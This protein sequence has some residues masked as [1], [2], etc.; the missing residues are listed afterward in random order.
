MARNSTLLKAFVALATLFVAAPWAADISEIAEGES[1]SAYC[2]KQVGDEDGSYIELSQKSSNASGQGEQCYEWWYRQNDTSTVYSAL[3]RMFRAEYPPTVVV[4]T[5]DLYFGGYDG[6]RCVSGANAYHPFDFGAEEGV[7]LSSI[8]SSPY[9]IKDLCYQGG[10]SEASF[11]GNLFTSIVNVNFDNL[12]LESQTSAGLFS[13]NVETANVINVHVSHSVVMAPVAGTLAGGIGSI[14]V[15]GFSG[16][17][18]TVNA[19]PEYDDGQSFSANE[20]SIGSLVGYCSELTVSSARIDSV[21]VLYQPVSGRSYLDAALPDG[22]AYVGGLVGSVANIDGVDLDE[23]ATLFQVGLENMEVVN[24]AEGD[25]V[26]HVGGLFGRMEGSYLSVMRTYTVGD[27]LCTSES[28]VQGYG[29]GIITLTD[30]PYVTIRANYHYSENEQERAQAFAGKVVGRYISDYADAAATGAPDTVITDE[31]NKAGYIPSYTEEY[32]DEEMVFVKDDVTVATGNYRNAIGD[33]AATDNFNSE[34]YTFEDLAAGTLQNGVLEG[35]YMRS[36]RFIEILDNVPGVLTAD[37]VE[38]KF[39]GTQATPYFDIGTVDSG[40]SGDSGGNSDEPIEVIFSLDCVRYTNCLTGDEL[41]ALERFEN[42]KMQGFEYEYVFTVG[43]DGT[44]ENTEWLE[45]AYGLTLDN[46]DRDPVYW[47]TYNTLSFAVNNVYEESTVYTLYLGEKPNVGPG[48]D[49]PETSE[50]K[51]FAFF[52]TG[53]DYSSSP[54]QLISYDGETLDAL[55][56]KIAESEFTGGNAALEIQAGTIMRIVADNPVTTDGSAFKGW[57]VRIAFGYTGSEKHLRKLAFAGRE[58]PVDE[59]GFINVARDGETAYTIFEDDPMSTVD[60][61]TEYGQL[62]LEYQKISAQAEKMISSGN[63]DQAEMRRLSAQADSLGD[64]MQE[65]G[66]PEFVLALAIFPK[67]FEEENGI[68]AYEPGGDEPGKEVPH[69]P[70]EPGWDKDSVR[71]DVAYPLLLQSGNAVQLNVKTDKFVFEGNMPFV[72]VFL[73]DLGGNTIADSILEFS[74]YDLPEIATWE[75]YALAPGMYLLTAKI[76]NGDTIEIRE[77][78]FE[79]KAQIADGCAGCWYMVS[80]A[81]VDLDNFNKTD[82]EAIY[83]WNESVLMGKYWQYEEVTKVSKIDLSRGYWYSSEEGTPLKL[84]GNTESGPEIRWEVDSVYSGW[85]MVANPYPWYVDVSSLEGLNISRW[86]PETGSYSRPKYLKPYEAVW[87][88]VS[89]GKEIMVPSA[90]VFADMVNADGNTVPYRSLQKSQ[91]LAKAAGSDEWSVQVSLSDAKGKMDSWN[92]LGVAGDGEREEEP[93]EGMGDHVNLSIVEGGAR[94]AKSVQAKNAS[95]AYEWD[96][97]VSAS[98]PRTAFLTLAGLDALRAYGLR[99]FVTIDG[100]TTEITE[101]T[102]MQVDVSSKAK[103]VNLR[104]A[105]EARPVVAC[106]MQNLHLSQNAGALQIAFD[107]S[108]GLAGAR[109][110]VDVVD[111]KG[112]V[113]RTEAFNAQAGE[114]AVSFEKPKAGLY[115]VRAVAGGKAAFQKVLLK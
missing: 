32:V 5:S 13:F 28:C 96:L 78:D 50:G 49:D 70:D 88:N 107:V 72:S 31:F 81:D 76:F 109:A 92:V 115:V 73:E 41:L 29:A 63:Y 99:A 40:N 77:W 44:I 84:N 68:D 89:S 66:E 59:D 57:T 1:T 55:G 65:I 58:L 20:V 94:L 4:L 102:K 79:V 8:G 19:I 46:A 71:M 56:D 51:A 82:A 7:T 83:W 86:N 14:T 69:E 12:H 110:R 60:P 62:V 87:V 114:N 97:S 36:A 33:I 47:D 39:D 105:R 10:A 42:N 6:S 16:N 26:N 25:G 106:T 34:D 17:S 67:G 93:P 23:S 108:E 22:N 3:Q 113:V 74:D 61:E 111:M 85:N 9:T 52:G 90:P 54:V 100:N 38:W 35:Q 2:V 43:E 64:L 30:E 15:S 45:F 37:E 112:N 104:I 95:E 27:I 98:S 80:F 18:L 21:N 75:H 101:G 24:E 11:S 91:R 53:V 103:N 48:D